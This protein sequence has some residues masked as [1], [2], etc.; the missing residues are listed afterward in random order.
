VA[1]EGLPNPHD[2]N[3]SRLAVSGRGARVQL[4]AKVGLCVVGITLGLLF[5]VSALSSSNLEDRQIQ[6]LQQTLLG[7]QEAWSDSLSGQLDEYRF[8]LAR[9]GTATEANTFDGVATI[10]LPFALA[11]SESPNDSVLSSVY[12]SALCGVI[13]LSFLVIASARLWFSIFIIALFLGARSRRPYVGD[14]ILGQTGNGRLFYSGVRAGLDNVAE[15]GAPD[16][17]VRGLACPEYASKS[18]THVS[19][20][21]KA[22]R[23]LHAANP[24]NESLA[25]ILVRHSDTAA[26]VPRLEDESRLRDSFTGGGLGEYVPHLLHAALKLHAQYASGNLQPVIPFPKISGPA[27]PAQYAQ[28]IYGA[29]NRVLTPQQRKAI[30]ALGANEV[31]TLVLALES[32]KVLAHSSE[33]GRWFR[34]SNSPHLS[35]RAVLH[36]IVSYPRDYG[37]E[38]REQLRQAIVY[39]LRASAFAPVRMPVEMGHTASAL[40]QWAEVLVTLPHQL[41]ESTE[42]VELFGL[43]REAHERWRDEVLP[44]ANSLVSD[45]F[46]SGFATTS[47]VL[48]LPVVVMVKLLRLTVTDRE[49]ARL[50]ELSAIIGARQAR[51]PETTT[52]SEMATTTALTQDRVFAPFTDRELSAISD[53]HGISETE[54]QEWSALRNILASHGWFARRVGDYTVPD[55]SVIY[56]V[57]KAPGFDGANALGFFG[58]KGLVPLRGGRVKECCGYDWDRRFTV[59]STAT[60]AESRDDFDNL[61]KGIKEELAPDEVSSTLTPA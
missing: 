59:F 24:T 28:S 30:G 26:F 9:H 27:D 61:L 3:L 12:I 41:Q 55:S 53:Q 43:V 31:A 40:R 45:F 8:W 29:L 48:F 42:E 20:I 19:S 18:E 47:H 33:G 36:S 60:M 54:L 6:H 17:L 13:R 10:L 37:F 1:V 5:L 52:P 14:D 23:Q 21:W 38:A 35:A 22:L 56:A 50:S 46:T 58:K 57:F 11:R 2:H 49:L 51:S 4:L 32:G 15:S 25:A 34:L 16:A 7:L 44:R 39:A